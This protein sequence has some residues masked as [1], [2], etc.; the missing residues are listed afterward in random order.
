MQREH[1]KAKATT[2]VCGRLCPL[3]PQ[4][5]SKGE[6]FR[7]DGNTLGVDSG[8]IGVFEEGDEVG[9]GGFLEGHDGGGL[10]AEVGLDRTRRQKGKKGK[11]H[12]SNS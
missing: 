8:K 6:I 10:E 12:V 3:A 2:T 9:L 11:S 7:L 5:P 4:S 1:K